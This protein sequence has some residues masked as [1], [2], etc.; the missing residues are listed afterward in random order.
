VTRECQA[1]TK[2]ANQKNKCP[3]LRENRVD[4]V[5]QSCFGVYGEV[6]LEGNFLEGLVQ[7]DP[8]R[9]FESGVDV[10]R[11]QALRQMADL[12]V[13]HRSMPELL[14]E[15]AKRL[16]QVA[17]FKIASFS[18]YDSEKNNANAVLGGR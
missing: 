15:L 3:C 8:E 9:H 13:H 4:D 10:D 6:L 5:S 16:Q 18:R 12:M 14:P 7:M 1:G 2:H 11:C 17:S